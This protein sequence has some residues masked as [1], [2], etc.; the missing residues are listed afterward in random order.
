MPVVRTCIFIVVYNVEL[1]LLTSAAVP[2]NRAAEVVSAHIS[3]E[4]IA[5]A[6]RQLRRSR[7]IAQLERYPVLELP[8]VVTSIPLEHDRAFAR[9]RSLDFSNLL[10]HHDHPLKDL[11]LHYTDVLILI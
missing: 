6:K 10:W 11:R 5:R 2:V 9:L 3:F 4:H 8:H 1:Q 7:E